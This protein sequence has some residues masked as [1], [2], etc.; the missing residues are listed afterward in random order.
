MQIKST[1]QRTVEITLNWLIK[2][3]DWLVMQWTLWLERWRQLWRRLRGP[4][5]RGIPF[6]LAM[7]GALAGLALYD[8]LTPPPEPLTGRDV[9]NILVEAMASAT[10]EPAYSSLVYQ[11]IL[12][13]IVYIKTFDAPP[14]GGDVAHA[15]DA[16]SAQSMTAISYQNAARYQPGDEDPNA[17]DFGLG[18]GVIINEDG[19]IL[20]ALHVVATAGAIEITFADGTETTA[21]IV[22]AEPENDIAVLQPGL[23]PELFLPA[24]LG[25][26]GAV[27]VGDEAYVVGHPLDL[28][29][30]MSAGVIS[31]LDRSYHFSH[32][33]QDLTGLI[34]FDAAVNSGNSG[35][36]LLNRYGQVI[37]I[38]T[39]LVNPTNQGVFIGVGMAV[40]IDVAAGGVGGGPAY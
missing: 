19:V 10:P 27:Q 29:A 2:L 38:V 30:S 40:P 25:N 36:P 9:E 7:L 8:Y 24:T 23:L 37:G 14:G 33:A 26:P 34:Q 28:Q 35:G 1:I 11:A 17:E 39:G 3:G 5:A 15:D 4:L 31:G 20:T 22:G 18:A 13:S 12:P 16:E 21:E 32:T 6:Y